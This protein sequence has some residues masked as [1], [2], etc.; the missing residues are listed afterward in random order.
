V[1]RTVTLTATAT[2]ERSVFRRWRGVQCARRETSERCS[3]A[4]ADNVTARAAFGVLPPATYTVQVSVTGTGKVSVNDIACP[5]PC[6]QTLQVGSPI[7]L[8]ATAG[9][10]KHWSNAP[11]SGQDTAATCSFTLTGNAHAEA[12]FTK[13][14]P[15]HTLIVKKSGTGTISGTCHGPCKLVLRA[16]SPVKLGATAAKG[17]VFDHWANAPCTDVSSSTSC[18][19]SLKGNE[20]VT[21]VFKAVPP[22]K[23]ALRVVLSGDGE[24]AG[25][26]TCPG[27]CVSILPDGTTVTLK[28]VE[29]G[30]PFSRWTD[31]PCADPTNKTCSFK[32]TSNTTATA[33]FGSDTY[34]VSVAVN[35]EKHGAVSGDVTCP[36]DCTQTLTA[37]NVVTLTAAPTY[38]EGYAFSEWQGDVCDRETDTTCSFPLN[39]NV[40][41]TAIFAPAVTLTIKSNSGGT[42]TID[43]TGI[44]CPHKCSA[45][46]AQNSTVAVKALAAEGYHIARWGKDCYGIGSGVG[47]SA[48]TCELDMNVSKS[49]SVVFAEDTG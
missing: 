21:A 34:T 26:V 37:G 28:A 32:L 46:F 29:S 6:S 40:S 22:G 25:S 49:V 8:T 9:H 2:G 4:L 23:H 31:V 27:R 20:T 44:Q 30:V 41:V 18:S 17:W 16:G 45:R 24:V 5:T 42:I 7:K 43:P 35:D 33:V 3:F 47:T 36:G 11:C 12:V 19:F 10:F 48:G 38:S 13:P 14:P 1:A 15:T 39:A